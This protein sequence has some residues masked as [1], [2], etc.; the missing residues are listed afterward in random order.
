M[1]LFDLGIV[2]NFPG[3]LDDIFLITFMKM[4]PPK[5]TLFW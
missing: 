2:K 5:I 3:D 1:Y 4:I